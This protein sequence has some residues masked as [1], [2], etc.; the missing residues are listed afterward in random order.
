M[1]ES[2]GSAGSKFGPL[3]VYRYHG[4]SLIAENKKLFAERDPIVKRSRARPHQITLP[5]TRLSFSRHNGETFPLDGGVPCRWR[6]SP[7]LLTSASRRT[8]VIP[9]S[10]FTGVIVGLILEPVPGAVVAM[11]V[12]PSSPFFAVLLFWPEHRPARV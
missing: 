2:L 3:I 5:E 9:G 6:S 4:N 10:A 12:Y 8:E 11:V 1:P 7:L